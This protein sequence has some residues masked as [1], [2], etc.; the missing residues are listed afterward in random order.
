LNSL[1]RIAPPQQLVLRTQVF[2]KKFLSA[3]NAAATFL[4]KK[5]LSQKNSK[6]LGFEP[7]SS[8]NQA[9]D[10]TTMLHRAY[11]IEFHHTKPNHKS[12]D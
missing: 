7:E 1:K 12:C 2:T 5:V 8:E 3:K 11:L 6:V 9:L 10:L 4:N